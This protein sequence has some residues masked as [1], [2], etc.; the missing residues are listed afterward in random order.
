MQESGGIKGSMGGEGVIGPAP[1]RAGE[2]EMPTSKAQAYVK[3][4]TYRNI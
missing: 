3:N 2:L 1:H 4:L